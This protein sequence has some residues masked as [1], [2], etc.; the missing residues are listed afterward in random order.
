MKGLYSFFFAVIM[1]SLITS[2]FSTG[3]SYSGGVSSSSAAASSRESRFESEDLFIVKT[4]ITKNISGDITDTYMEIYDVTIRSPY[5][6]RTLT[7]GKRSQNDISISYIDFYYFG[8]DWQFYDTILI[9]LN[10]NLHRL[11]T[12]NNDRDTTGRGNV[13]ES[14]IAELTPD[15]IEEFK[16]CET[17]VFQ[18]NGRINS[19]PLEVDTQGI[20]AINNFFRENF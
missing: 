11:E 2:C 7:V 17:I 13:T 3:S 8:G 14:L 20:V 9:K 6:N 15:I 16:S 10:D 12:M 19:E 5:I 1:G 4:D 18:V